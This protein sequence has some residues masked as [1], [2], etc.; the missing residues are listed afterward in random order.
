MKRCSLCLILMLLSLAGVSAQIEENPQDEFA[1]QLAR[2]LSKDLFELNSVPF[3]E[4]LV[5]TANAATNAGFFR[6]AT[7]PRDDTLYFRFS[8]VGMSGLVG[9]D[10]QFFA[11]NLP[12]EPGTPEGTPFLIALTYDELKGV[13]KRG[14][15]E[16]WID[17]PDMAATIFGPKEDTPINIPKDSLLVAVQRTLAYSLLPA[18]QKEQVDDA[19]N[20]LPVSQNLPGGADL[21]QIF[22]AVPQLEIGAL[23][24]S[25]LLLRY[26]PP[27]EFSETVGKLSFFGLALRHSV[28]QYFG[29]APYFDLAIQGAYQ[30]TSIENTIGVTEAELTA[31]ADIFNLNMHASKRFDIFDVYTGLSFERIKVD[32]SYVYTLPFSIQID[33]GLLKEDPEGSANYVT[34]P[35]EFPGDTMPQTSSVTLENNNVKWVVGTAANFDPITVFIDY[36]ISQFNILSGGI[37]V[38]F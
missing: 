25:E 28:S 27:I 19:I 32:A 37:M 13:F 29:D 15:E 4:P 34:D 23:Y 35:P 11:P 33:L 2:L 17:I 18:D 36:S 16:G 3:L 20:S 8:L 6:N 10:R 24:G 5:I 22:A 1:V 14:K 30:S 31:D 7:I 12:T 9:D 21:S 26:I 38:S